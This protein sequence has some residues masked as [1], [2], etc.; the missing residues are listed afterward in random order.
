[1]DN[2]WEIFWKSQTYKGYVG[3]LDD[4]RKSLAMAMLYRKFYDLNT[5]DPKPINQALADLKALVPICN[6]KINIT[7]YQTLPKGESWLHEVWSG[8]MLGAFFAYLPSGYDGS[9]LRFWSPPKGKGQVQNDCWAIVATSKKPVLG[10]LWLNYL[11]DKDFAYKNFTGFTGYQ[12]PQVSITA[13]ELIEQ[14][15]IPENLRTAVFTSDAFGSDSLQFCALTPKGSA[16]W[17]KA[18]AR[19]NS[20]A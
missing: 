12:P 7:E 11:L 1:M 15:V 4:A 13:D 10:H 17:Q 3:V 9:S 6:P 8:D 20:G 19:F 14:K 16:L 2:P 5:E 18:Y